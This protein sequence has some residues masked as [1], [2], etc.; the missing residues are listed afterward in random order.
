[1]EDMVLK[2]LGETYKL[3]VSNT[4]TS[5]PTI[6]DGTTRVLIQVESQDIRVKFNATGSTTYCVT[7][8]VGGGI[9]L[10]VSTAGNPYYIF[11]GRDLLGNMRMYRGG[12]TDSYVNVVF[13]GLIQPSAYNGGLA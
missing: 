10:P 3:T 12:S 6:P 9:L 2:T 11:D 4:V 13:L 8:G 1:M 7:A 5:L